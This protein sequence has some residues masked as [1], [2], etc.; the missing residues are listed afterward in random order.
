MSARHVQT[1]NDQ[2]AER[3][4]RYMWQDVTSVKGFIMRIPAEAHCLF[5]SYSGNSDAIQ[6]VA[7]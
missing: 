4:A 7:G 2:Q 3:P 6:Y 1:S 5:M